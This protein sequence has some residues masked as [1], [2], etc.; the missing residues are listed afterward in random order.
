PSVDFR[1]NLS[2]R[3]DHENCIEPVNDNETNGTLLFR[4]SVSRE[5]RLEVFD[6][7]ARAIVLDVQQANPF[8]L[9]RC[10]VE[11]VDD[12][13]E[14]ADVAAAV[15]Q[16]NDIPRIV[17]DDCARFAQI[18]HQDLGHLR[19]RHEFHAN[20]LHDDLIVRRYTCL[21]IDYL[22]RLPRSRIGGHDL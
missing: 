10:G 4:E 17:D 20:D 8:T 19:R 15:S 16:Q 7:V 3:R 1:E 6:D 12:L 18:W 22:D 9:E 13:Q 5:Y 21:L 11:N 2:V 14:F